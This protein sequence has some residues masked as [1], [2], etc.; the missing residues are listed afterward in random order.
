MYTWHVLIAPIE[1]D[2]LFGMDFLFTHNADSLCRVPCD[3][4]ECLC[5]DGKQF[6]VTCHLEDVDVC[7]RKHEQWSSFQ[8]SG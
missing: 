1:E 7:Q 3:L 6:C 5:Y 4:T 2:G 8:E